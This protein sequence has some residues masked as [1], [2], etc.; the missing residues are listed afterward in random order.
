MY[1]YA[2]NQYQIAFYANKDMKQFMVV[3][4]SCGRMWENVVLHVEMANKS[5]DESA[6][7]P[8]QLLEETIVKWTLKRSAPHESKTVR[9]RDV[10]VSIPI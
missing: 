8:S 1:T 3:G 7:I 6:I 10:R 5:K 2:Y 4:Q 9:N